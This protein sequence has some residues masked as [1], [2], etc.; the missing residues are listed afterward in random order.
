MPKRFNNLKAALTFLR[1]P[2]A[3]PNTPVPDAP[4]G[5]VLKNFQDYAAGKVVTTRDGSTQGAQKRTTVKPFATGADTV[6]YQITVSVNAMDAAATFGMSTTILGQ[7]DVLTDSVE[8]NGFRPARAVISN[9][10][11]AGTSTP[12][13]ITKKPYKKKAASSR[14]FPFGSTTSNS[15]YAAQKA[16]IISEV[17]KSDTRGVSFLPEIF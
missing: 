17:A 13:Q 15:T 7:N 2:T 3:D 16:V 6:R 1:T 8:A 10:T 12:S 9:V 4:T 11:G 5:T 14:V